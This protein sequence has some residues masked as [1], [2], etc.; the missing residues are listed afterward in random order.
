MSNVAMRTSGKPFLM[1][2]LA[3][4][5]ALSG[6]QSDAASKVDARKVLAEI[7]ILGEQCGYETIDAW[8]VHVLGNLREMRAWQQT[9]EAGS[10]LGETQRDASL[11]Y[12]DQTITFMDRPVREIGLHSTTAD[13]LV[14]ALIYAA[15]WRKNDRLFSQPVNYKWELEQWI[16]HYA[17][18]CYNREI[19]R[20]GFT[21]S[22]KAKC[23]ITPDDKPMTVGL[24]PNFKWPHNPIVARCGFNPA[25]R[26]PALTADM[27]R[28]PAYGM[29]PDRAGTAAASAPAPSAGGMSSGG[30]SPG[31]ALPGGTEK[32][33]DALK[34]VGLGLWSRLKSAAGVGI[35]P[36][37]QDGT[38]PGG[39]PAVEPAPQLPS[40]HEAPGAA[41]AMAPASETANKPGGPRAQDVMGIRLG[42]SVAEV[43]KALGKSHP[44][45]SNF[46]IRS[47]GYG[48][49]WDGLYVSLPAEVTKR[50]NR[51]NKKADEVVIV[52]FSNPPGAQKALAVVRYKRYA[53][54]KTPS[55]AATEAS[56][57]EKYGPW[58]DMRT[59]RGANHY[60]W[61]RH[62]RTGTSCLPVKW[63][64]PVYRL[65][66]LTEAEGSTSV[67][68]QGYGKWDQCVKPA[69]GLI[70]FSTELRGCGVQAGAY[71][72]FT[73][74]GGKDSSPVTE[75]QTFIAD[76]DGMLAN[77]IAFADL[78]K[79]VE[80]RR[81][82]DAIQAGGKPAL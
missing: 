27:P 2:C 53:K 14:N 1:T 76:V 6:A 36:V 12:L 63:V 56:L 67:I 46:V 75:L 82:Q 80:K 23:E 69:R 48:K 21:D 71:V 30:T 61:G 32:S 5:A 19:R 28:P 81:D 29:T 50:D 78:A 54:D 64:D 66:D 9:S 15:N 37:P 60:T 4:A 52:D 16:G 38:S 31:G 40:V 7:Q 72:R 20:R 34:G 39:A 13:K 49:E 3:V 41:P 33:L 77:E 26:N 65:K 73:Q 62:P 24:F 17:F 58:D 8:R 25:K 10:I 42:M 11:A 18:A 43:K 57:V 44:S 22:S 79:G 47:E 74:K 55:L 59:I 70:E 35:D 68:C 51:F 45:S